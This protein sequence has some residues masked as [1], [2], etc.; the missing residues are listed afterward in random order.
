MILPFLYF[1]LLLV[2][3]F[4]LSA[5]SPSLR[6]ICLACCVTAESAEDTASCGIRVR[7]HLVSPFV[8]FMTFMV[9]AS[10]L[11]LP[12]RAL[13]HCERP[14]F[15]SR[16]DRQERSAK[17]KS[18]DRLLTMKDVKSMKKTREQPNQD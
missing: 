9:D 10:G 2:M 13:R 17:S 6:G 14:P 7:K 15:I 8:S 12:P 3:L 16:K 18:P 5:A 11:V 4:L 1:M